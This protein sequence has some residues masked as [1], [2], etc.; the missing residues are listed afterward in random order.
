MTLFKTLMALLIQNISVCICFSESR[1]LLILTE[2][3][4]ALGLLEQELLVMKNAITI[5]GSS[6]RR[7]QEYTQVY[8]DKGKK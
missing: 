8:L 7:D 5:F 3:Y 6:F 1:Y 4:A 2:N